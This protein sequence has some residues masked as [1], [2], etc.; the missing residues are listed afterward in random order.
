[1]QAKH[2]QP[3]QHGG[4]MPV[5]K[6]GVKPKY[7]TAARDRLQAPVLFTGMWIFNTDRQRPQRYDGA[8]WVELP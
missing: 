7:S 6:S 5:D 2:P 3:A 8:G 4:L 1:M